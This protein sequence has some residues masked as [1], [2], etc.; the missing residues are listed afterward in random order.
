MEIAKNKLN[1]PEHI[2][3]EIDRQVLEFTEQRNNEEYYRQN[4]KSLKALINTYKLHLEIDAVKKHS[5]QEKLNNRGKR[6]R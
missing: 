1:L 3:K 2:R 6:I 4:P 5:I